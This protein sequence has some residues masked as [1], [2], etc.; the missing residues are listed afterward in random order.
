M[1]RLKYPFKASLTNAGLVLLGLLMASAAIEGLVRV[2]TSSH[3]NYLIEMWRYATLLKRKSA[4]PAV[5][6]EHI[7]GASARLQGVDVSINSLGMR[8]PEPDL[9]TAGKR[10]VVLIGDSTAM[11]WGL[12][13]A[14][15]LRA[16]LAAQLGDGAEVMTT[17]V[18]NMNMSQIVA[19]WL[20]YA[21]RIRPEAV[22]VLATARAPALQDAGEAGWLVRHS[23]AYALLVSFVEIAMANT[24][25]QAGLVEGYRKVWSDGP[26][27]DA[28]N[29]AL[30]A[31]KSNQQKYGYR[32]LVMLVPE[33][34]DFSAYQFGF[35]TAAMRHE[36]EK[37]GWLFMDPLEN[38]QKDP[39]ESYWVAR[40][41]VHPN[42]KAFR[43][44]TQM[45]RPHLSQ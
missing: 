40:N 5:G 2:A 13:E 27:R 16:Q 25:G 22:I 20:R 38:L 18:G 23:Q 39:A 1:S 12:P 45:L 7:P 31:L 11:G 21:D 14:E 8:G 24:P 9:D 43:V 32:V 4:D 44:M 6:H 15:T 29:S 3:Q 30:D 17:G 26:G 35:M 10:K 33:P 37:R 19:N 28:M 36:S 42:A 34:H 41:D